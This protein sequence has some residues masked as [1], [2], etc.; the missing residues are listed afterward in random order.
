MAVYSVAR[1]PTERDT[2][3][4]AETC[5]VNMRLAKGIIGEVRETV[6]RW[7]EFARDAD[8]SAETTTMAQTAIAGAVPA[9]KTYRAHFPL[10]S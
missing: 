8:V 4:V 2:F 10:T 5:A 3:S 7:P 6:A 1:N 9:A